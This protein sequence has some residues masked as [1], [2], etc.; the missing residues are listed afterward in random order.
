LTTSAADRLDRLIE[1]FLNHNLLERGLALNTVRAYAADLNR[2][3]VYLHE[4]RFTSPDAVTLDDI[5]TYLA[6]LLDRGLS[7]ASLRRHITVIKLWHRW[8][9]ARG[10][11]AVDLASRVEAPRVDRPL[12][13][14]L[15]PEDVRTILSR[16]DTTRALGIRNRAI[17]ELLYGG[18]L[19]ISELIGLKSSDLIPTER[20]LRI[21]GKGD[22]ERIVPLGRQGWRWL[23]RYRR[24]SRPELV[25]N[26]TPFLFLNRQG[27]P[28]SRMGVWKIIRKYAPDFE[29]VSPHTFR[30]SFAT[31]LLE[32]GASLR[33]VQ[34]MLGHS[35]I[36]TTQIYTHLNQRY[37]RDI[38]QKHHPRG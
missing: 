8:L 19:R 3:S 38:H 30:H 23:D 33:A 35:D 26:R 21:T 25:R 36:T 27:K 6:G 32:G 24:R 11:V 37:L 20:L 5:T 12:P 18:G 31:H 4:R 7:R 16:P 17:L 22:K 1:Q 9:K 15:S 10:E 14:V 28:L 34:E 29:Q 2:Y 13:Y